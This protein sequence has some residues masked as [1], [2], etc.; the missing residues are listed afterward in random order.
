MDSLLT[1][2]RERYIKELDCYLR[3]LLDEYSI[4][5]IVKEIVGW[6][7]IDS[8]NYF[9]TTT[10]ARDF[11]I[12]SDLT[13]QEKKVF[14]DELVRQGFFEQLS[15][16]LYSENLSVCSWTIYTI[17]KFSENENATF[18]ETAYEARYKLTNPILSYRCLSE[19]SWLESKKLD[20]Y[21]QELELDTSWISKLILLYYWLPRGYS[22][23]FK[24]LL[25]DKALISFIIPDRNLVDIEDEVS[26][27][28]FA[29]EQHITELY[30]DK[31]KVEQEDFENIAK[32]FFATYI[33][34]KN[35]RA[36]KD[37]EEFLKRFRTE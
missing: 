32:S 22:S 37:H 18:L 25:R 21:L 27:R 30:N 12:G 10:F 2:L 33:N 6:L 35:E 5:E 20:G 15:N 11:I 23:N 9:D 34:T 16:F 29:F 1:F 17:G 13:E 8:L 31:V 14:Y 3:F 4:E 26:D 7:K 24:D 36:D 19:L 28:L